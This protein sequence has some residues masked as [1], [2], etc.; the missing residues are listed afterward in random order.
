MPME[1]VNVLVTTPIGDECLRQITAISPKIKIRDV[2]DLFG[3]EQSG[4]FSS[5]E[6]FD[7]LLAEAE[8]FCE[9]LRRYL[10][11]KKLMNVVNKKKGY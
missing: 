7:T 4:G 2:S 10:S 3:A 5:K 9:N 6:C 11:G 8:M 1:S